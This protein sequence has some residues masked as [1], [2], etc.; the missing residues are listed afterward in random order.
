MLLKH[1]YWK[2]CVFNT[3]HISY[4]V[5][6]RNV[7]R[8][9]FPVVQF[10]NQYLSLSTLLPGTESLYGLGEHKASLKLKKLVVLH[11]LLHIHMYTIIYICTVTQLAMYTYTYRIAGIF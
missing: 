2:L 8:M 7:M 4:A 11:C 3:V 9:V 5:G 10:A 6:I 1:Q